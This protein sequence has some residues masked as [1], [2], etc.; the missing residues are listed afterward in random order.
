M[1]RKGHRSL[2]RA[3][4]SAARAKAGQSRATARCRGS[5][6]TRRR[7]RADGEMA[8]M[9]YRTPVPSRAPRSSP[10]F[11]LGATVR[12]VLNERN[13]TPHVGMVRKV[14]WHFKDERYNYYLEEN[15][16]KVSKRYFDEDLELAE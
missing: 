5:M 11:E 10:R 3:D 12:V 1:E 13:R 16:R 8:S 15:G 2:G 14:I 4:R 7:Q 9:V 6:G